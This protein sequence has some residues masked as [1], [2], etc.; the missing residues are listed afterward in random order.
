ML[1][2]VLLNEAWAEMHVELD[3]RFRSNALKAVDLARLDHQ[4]VTRAALEFLPVYD[5]AA[6]AFSHEL[7][8]IIRMPVRAWSPSGQSAQQE[9]GYVYV[10]LVGADELV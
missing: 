9:D 4:D 6:T 10:T 8:F 3:Q 1:R 7:H 2:Q 5:P